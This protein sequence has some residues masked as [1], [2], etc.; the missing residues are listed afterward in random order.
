[1]A[2]E[3]RGI[4][5]RAFGVWFDKQGFLI[6]YGVYFSP[7]VSLDENTSYLVDQTTNLAYKALKK[8]FSKTRAFHSSEIGSPPSS[9]WGNLSVH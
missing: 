9:A 6:I 2:V 1:M 5:G 4:P 8:I 7:Y 3:R